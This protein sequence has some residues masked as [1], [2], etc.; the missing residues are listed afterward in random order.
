MGLNECHSNWLIILFFIKGTI[1]P[2]PKPSGTNPAEITGYKQQL[3]THYEA[4][5]CIQ[6]VLADKTIRSTGFTYRVTRKK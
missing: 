3:Q 5:A 4:W 6:Q 2:A 1:T